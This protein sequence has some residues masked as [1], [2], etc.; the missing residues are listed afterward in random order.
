LY[1][2]QYFICGKVLESRLFKTVLY[3]K[4]KGYTPLARGAILKDENVL[5]M[6]KKYS[7]TASQIAIRWS[8]QVRFEFPRKYFTLYIVDALIQ[9]YASEVI[10]F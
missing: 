2:K 4:F 6:A 9:N 7:K 1:Q 8:L 5:E 3:L 10:Q